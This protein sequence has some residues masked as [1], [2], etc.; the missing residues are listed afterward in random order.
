MASKRLRHGTSVDLKIAVIG[1]EDTI[2]G[3]LMAGVG[4]KDGLGLSNFFV[5]DKDTKRN[6]VEET[7]RVF[8]TRKDIGV[9]LIN[10]HIAEDIRYLVD[11]HR[12]VIPTILEIGSKDHPYDPVKDSVMQRVK[13]F[14]GG[15]ISNT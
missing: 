5:V 10:Q 1:D 8:S 13:M 7:F 15:D 14:F 3:F 4:G 6:D 12:V 2:T 11:S 9:I